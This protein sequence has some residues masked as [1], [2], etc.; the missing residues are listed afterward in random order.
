MA[1]GIP[2]P[3]ANDILRAPTP[4][5]AAA[6]TVY[7]LHIHRYADL[8]GNPNVI[9][10]WQFSPDELAQVVAAGGTFW[11][12]AWGHTHPP[13]GIEGATPFVRGARSPADAP[14]LPADAVVAAREAIL[15]SLRD[16]RLLKYLFAEEPETRAAY[17]YVDA[18]IDL[19]TQL[20]CA[21]D[22]ARLAIAAFLANPAPQA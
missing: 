19:D 1:T 17:G 6:G 4:E 10:K 16:R 2:F 13:V 3:E 8:D 12:H 7:D 20:E 22:L 14:D 15:K 11:F 9:S 21:E 18:P 5:D